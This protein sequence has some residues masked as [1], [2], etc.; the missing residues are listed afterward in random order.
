MLGPIPIAFGSDVPSLKV[1]MIVAIVLMIVAL[2]FM[3][4]PWKL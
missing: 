3:L 2:M 4:F 1:V